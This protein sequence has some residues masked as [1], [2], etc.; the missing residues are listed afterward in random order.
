VTSEP[1]SPHSLVRKNDRG[2]KGTHDGAIIANGN[3]YCPA[4]PRSLLELGPLARTATP[5]Q[6]AAHDGKTAETATWRTASSAASPATT[7]TDTT[8]SPAPPP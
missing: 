5:G 6:A 2:P 1:S 4:T 7:K 3:L 8:A